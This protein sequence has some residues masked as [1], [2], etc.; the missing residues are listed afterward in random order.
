MFHFNLNICFSFTKYLLSFQNL[1]VF[2]RLKR[3]FSSTFQLGRYIS[4]D[5]ERRVVQP[6]PLHLPLSPDGP[7]SLLHLSERG[8]PLSPARTHPETWQ[9]LRRAED[10]H[11]PLHQ[12]GQQN[13]SWTNI[14]SRPHSDWVWLCFFAKLFNL[15]LLLNIFYA[16][17]PWSF[18]LLFSMCTNMKLLL[19]NE[20][21]VVELIVGN[22]IYYVC[23]S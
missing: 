13:R 9:R 3:F 18:K 20:K 6:A 12:S 15:C 10:R 5:Q 17:K 4:L 1:E 8:V 19:Y 22:K 7:Q 2:R 21:S 16:V 11:L 23:S 14:A